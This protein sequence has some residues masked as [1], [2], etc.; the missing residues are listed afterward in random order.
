MIKL[1]VFLIPFRPRVVLRL[2][3]VWLNY[4]IYFFLKRQENTHYSVLV[5]LMRSANVTKVD[6]RVE[7]KVE[8]VKDGNYEKKKNSFFS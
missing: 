3:C 1:W 4:F 5:D 2:P 7:N 6:N 8:I